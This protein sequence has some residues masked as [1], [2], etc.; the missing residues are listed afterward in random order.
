[1]FKPNTIY[2][3]FGADPEDFKV[4]LDTPTRAKAIEFIR[5]HVDDIDPARR[6]VRANGRMVAYDY[7]SR[8]ALDPDAVLVELYG[9]PV[10]GQA[11][12]R[13]PMTR[14]PSVPGPGDALVYRAS[15]EAGRPAEHFT[16]R[17]VPLHPAARVPLEAPPHPVA[18]MTPSAVRHQATGAGDR[19]GERSRTLCGVFGSRGVGE[20]PA[21]PARQPDPPRRPP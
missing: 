21:W 1:V 2:I 18:A 16:P 3:P 14:S 4:Y 8:W 20:L 9:D 10:D 17:T 19:R 5:G 15:V 6:T 11:A 13:A 12:V 7:L